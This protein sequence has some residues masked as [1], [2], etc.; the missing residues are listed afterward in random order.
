M[1]LTCVVC[2]AN[3]KKSD[4]IICAVCNEHQ[5]VECMIK[6]MPNLTPIAKDNIAK[7]K[8]GYSFGCKN[9][10]S[11]SNN[12]ATQKMDAIEKQ[13]SDLTNIIKN[14]VTSQLADIKEEL[15]KA[16]VNNKKFEV[17]I[18]NKIE[19][20]EFENNY[21]RKQL[22]RS[23]ILV[24]G[25]PS[26]LTTEELYSTAL[27]I[28]KACDVNITEYDVNFCAWIRKKSAVLMKFNNTLKRD[29]LMN[30]YR[31]KYNLKLC[32]IMSTDIEKRIYLNN[33]FIPIEGKLHYMCRIKIKLGEIKSYRIITYN[34]PIKVKLVYPNKE[35][36]I[37]TAEDFINQK[38]NHQTTGLTSDNVAIDTNAVAEPFNQ[39][40]GHTSAND[41]TTAE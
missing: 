41:V 14:S 1:A 31:K 36:R 33:H 23:D 20:L 25:L 39:N 17:E 2:S 35:E 21:L 5:H 9:C 40:M 7:V 11:T 38:T 22:N 24:G 26:N 8:P 32:D 19:N 34:N 37:V 15:T 10:R 6:Q 29:T 13:L 3:C 30:N 27:S 28:G 4:S 18:N 12:P 16:I